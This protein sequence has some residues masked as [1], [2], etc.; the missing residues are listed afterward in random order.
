[1]LVSLL[2]VILVIIIIIITEVIEK[3]FLFVFLILTILFCIRLNLLSGLTTVNPFFQASRH[4]RLD[5]ILG[6]NNELYYF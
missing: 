3:T 5:Y 1:M 4:K 2:D 6:E